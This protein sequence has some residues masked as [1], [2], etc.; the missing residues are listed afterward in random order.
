MTNV[1]VAL[2]VSLLCIIGLYQSFFTID[3][4]HEVVHQGD[5]IWT[6]PFLLLPY[7]ALALAI[8]L[9]LL[10]LFVVRMF[11]GDRLIKRFR[12]TLY[13]ARIAMK[14]FI[15]VTGDVS[16]GCIK[17]QPGEAF[18]QSC[19]DQG[20]TPA[21]AAKK[22]R[23]L[24]R[25]FQLAVERGQLEENPLRLLKQPRRPRR[26][27]RV[28][29]EDECSRLIKAAGE[30]QN[31][32]FAKKRRN[33]VLIDWELL[34]RTAL[35]SG[36]RRGELLNATW[37]DVD[38]EKRT[39]DVAPKKETPETWEWHI[40]DT[41]RRTLPLTDE[42]VKLLAKHHTE[43]PEGYPYVFIP[44]ARYISI[45]QLRKQGKWSVQRGCVPLNNFERQFKSI[46]KI[47]GIVDAE[48][49]DI[50]R[51]CLT[52]CLAN[53]LQELDV[54]SMA[55]HASFETTRQFYLA[56]RGDL[57]ERTR[58]A[59]GKAMEEISVA[60]LLQMPFNSSDPKDHQP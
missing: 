58:E 32:R 23:H 5:K 11:R 46:L 10:L 39:I 22:L 36:M 2:C 34:V 14:H 44:P 21:T 42:I 48:F 54:M 52:N 4:T 40:K 41:E 7:T 19:L 38:F 59:S 28:L 45:Q 18:V 51:T 57:I 55:G 17:Y 53:G 1:I 56:V 8:L 47:A 49:H 24:K 30:F 6:L 13:Q 26:K 25:L 43:Q 12:K 16:C 31:L 37:K 33:L 15:R 50:R 9:L 27:V 3:K 20:N 60:N 35:C 29:S